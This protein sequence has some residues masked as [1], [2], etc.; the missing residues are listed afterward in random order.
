MRSRRFMCCLRS[1]I[2]SRA[3]STLL[4]KDVSFSGVLPRNLFL[5]NLMWS[6][7]FNEFSYHKGLIIKRL[8]ANIK[9]FQ[10]RE[11]FSDNLIWLE[12]F[13]E[14]SYHKGLVNKRLVTNIKSFQNREV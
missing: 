1:S 3:M 12:L 13:N 4:E 7:S 8:V 14:F 2:S 9:L 11:I 6:E 10:N 5:E